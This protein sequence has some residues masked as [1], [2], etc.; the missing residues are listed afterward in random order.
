MISASE[1]RANM[2][3]KILLLEPM[4]SNVERWG[5]FSK[6]SGLNPPLGLFSIYAYMKEKKFDIDLIDTQIIPAFNEEVHQ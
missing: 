5:S 4:Q 3:K 2:N 1:E 6:E